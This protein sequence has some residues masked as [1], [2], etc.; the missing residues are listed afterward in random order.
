MRIAAGGNQ[1]LVR[2][3]H[4]I[5]VQIELRLRELQIVLHVVRLRGLRLGKLC[6][7]LG[8]AFLFGVEQL[9]RF[10][11]PILILSAA[12]LKRGGCASTSRS[13]AVKA[14][15]SSWS[16]I[17]SA[18]FTH[19]EIAWSD[20]RARCRMTVASFRLPAADGRARRLIERADQQPALRNLDFV[21]RPISHRHVRRVAVE[22][23][24]PRD[25]RMVTVHQFP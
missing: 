16:A 19:A 20:P 11:Q 24:D 22:R 15:A 13:A 18:D 3:F 21:Q 17:R 10:L 6:G 12:G 23:I 1:F 14:S 2:L 5:V 25:P 8:D 4:F 7:L 9:C